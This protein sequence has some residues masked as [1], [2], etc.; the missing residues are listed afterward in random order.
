MWIVVEIWSAKHFS[1]IVMLYLGCSLEVDTTTHLFVI[2]SSVF[3]T[4]NISKE[5]EHFY[6]PDGL[7]IN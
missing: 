6:H 3:I 1:R 7:P 4:M 2:G 5:G